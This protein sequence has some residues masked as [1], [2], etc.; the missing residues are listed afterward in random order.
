MSYFSGKQ[1]DDEGVVICALRL[2]VRHRHG[3]GS[4]VKAR[5][6]P[7]GENMYSPSIVK[8]SNVRML[9]LSPG[10]PRRGTVSNQHHE[11]ILAA[12]SRSNI[13]AIGK[14]VVEKAGFDRIFPALQAS[15][16]SFLSD[17]VNTI[18]KFAANA[19]ET[20]ARP[21]RDTRRGRSPLAVDIIK[22]GTPR[23]P[24]RLTE[25]FFDTTGIAVHTSALALWVVFCRRQ[26]LRDRP[27]P[28]SS[29]FPKTRIS[30]CRF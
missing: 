1:T 21:R 5:N 18:L 7:A 15:P 26:A 17:S 29:V 3:R 14:Q 24:R 30:R 12:C 13:A 19:S 22:H 25:G 2:G 9:S 11:H 28:M 23:F 10:A 6:Q 27:P 20:K 16:P 8:I 4:T